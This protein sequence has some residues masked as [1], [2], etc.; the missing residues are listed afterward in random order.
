MHPMLLH[1]VVRSEVVSIG[2]EFPEDGLRRPKHVAIQCDFN[3]IL[4]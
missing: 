4:K 3:D 2:E 1:I